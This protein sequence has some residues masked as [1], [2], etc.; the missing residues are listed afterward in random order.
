MLDYF[1]KQQENYLHGPNMLVTLALYS[2]LI[3]STNSTTIQS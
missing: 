1:L 2:R 3:K